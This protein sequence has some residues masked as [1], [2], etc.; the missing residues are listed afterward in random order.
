MHAV[1]LG[2]TCPCSAVFKALKRHVQYSMTRSGAG[3]QTSTRAS[4]PIKELYQVIAMHMMNRKIMPGKNRGFDG[5][6]YK[7]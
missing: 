2:L 6:L 7:L 3:V 1:T 5:V 4:P